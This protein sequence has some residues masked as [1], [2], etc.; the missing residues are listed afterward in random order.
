MQELYQIDY[1]LECYRHGAYNYFNDV[2]ARHEDLTK[3]SSDE[4][5]ARGLDPN[6]DPAYA[7]RMLMESGVS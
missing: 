5:E 2:I 7:N 6:Y 4:L 3:L 1:D